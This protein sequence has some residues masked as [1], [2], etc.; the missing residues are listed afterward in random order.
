MLGAAALACGR[1]KA[2]RIHAY[3]L[4]ANRTDRSVAVVDL[5]TFRLR[6]QIAIDGAPAQLV[7]HPSAPKVFALAPEAGSIHEIDAGNLTAGRT[8]HA[9]AQAAGLRL[10]PT[11]QTLW[12]L[13]RDPPSLVELPINTMR[14]GRRIRL[15]SPPDDFDLSQDGQA[16]IVS[17]QDRSI[18][19]ASLAKGTI[20]REIPAGVEPSIARFHWTGTQVLVGSRADRNLTIFD[21]NG[22]V[23]VRLPLPLAPRNFCFTNDK[24]GQLFISGDGMDAVVIVFPYTTEVEQTILAGHA[25]DAMVVTTKAPT[26]LLIANP[27]SNGVTVLDVD[28]RSL[29]SQVQVGLEPRS[30][31]MTPGDEYAL[32]VNHTSGDLAVIRMLS[33]LQ[34]PNGERRLNFSAPLFTM[35]PVG[36]NPVSAVVL[37]LG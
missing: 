16:A 30:I 15:A 28:T 2:A 14:P 20:T 18:V 32:V 37:D 13:Y 3:C 19:L 25:P 21:V 31:V 4:V 1:P 5:N 33:L 26:L 6:R 7:V 17:R 29:I 35:V 34:T 23:V 9:G 24:Q 36:R 12:V 11:S 22:K 10:D 8:V 27:E